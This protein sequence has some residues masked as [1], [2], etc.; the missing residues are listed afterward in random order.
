M[1]IGDVQQHVL[2]SFDF[3]HRIIPYLFDMVQE[4]WQYLESIAYW[5]NISIIL[6][7]YGLPYNVE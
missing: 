4:I 6:R 1:Y 2:G 3:F 7:R 5:K